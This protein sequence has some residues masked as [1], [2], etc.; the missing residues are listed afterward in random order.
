MPLSSEPSASLRERRRRKTADDIQRATLRLIL[1]HGFAQVTTDMIAAEAGVST[2]TFFNYFPNKEAATVGVSPEFTAEG[3]ARFRRAE[4]SLAEDL[5]VLTHD[6]FSATPGHK[7]LVRII[8]AVIDINPAL[9]PAFQRSMQRTIATVAELLIARRPELSP[10]HA[11]MMAEV[12]SVVL[13]HAL[14]SWSDSNSGDLH[15]VRDE[16]TASLRA[17]GGIMTGA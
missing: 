6:L 3:I 13:G 9:L 14:R 4:G 8:C 15:S 1:A 12:Y 17:L 11:A 5:G 16:I 10:V 2:R 7:E